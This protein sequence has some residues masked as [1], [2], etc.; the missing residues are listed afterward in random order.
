MKSLKELIT[1][2]KS[3]PGQLTFGTSGVGSSNHMWA[4]S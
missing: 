2:A 4:S 1:L 3:K